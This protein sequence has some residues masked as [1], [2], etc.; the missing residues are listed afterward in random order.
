MDVYLLPRPHLLPRIHERLIPYYESPSAQ[1]TDVEEELKSLGSRLL[2][3]KQKIG[4]M[5]QALIDRFPLH[6]RLCTL[7]GSSDSIQVHYP[8]SLK[9][10]D[11][12]YTFDHFLRRQISKH[13]F[14]LTINGILASM[15]ALLMPLPGP[16]IFFFYPAVRA[17]SHYRARSGAKR[18]ASK[19]VAF[20]PS[21]L[22]GEFLTSIHHKP[23]NKVIPLLKPL[24]GKMG[25]PRLPDYYQEVILH[26]HA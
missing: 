5:Y 17:F 8:D 1:A 7:L 3:W 15:G 12:R 25:L 19:E 13:R 18:A 9:V 10:E 2:R 6:E 16:N 14:W 4:E 22:L 11:A 20:V 26:R 23:R 24:A 21:R